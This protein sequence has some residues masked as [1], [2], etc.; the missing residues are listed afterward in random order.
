MVSV[1]SRAKYEPEE[2]YMFLLY[3]KAEQLFPCKE[4]DQQLHLENN[5]AFM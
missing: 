1:N 2:K 5:A 3:Y 4:F